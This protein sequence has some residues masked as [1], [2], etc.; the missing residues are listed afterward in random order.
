MGLGLRGHE[1]TATGHSEGHGI[2]PSPSSGGSRCGCRCGLMSP[3]R[4]IQPGEHRY[5]VTTALRQ[6][7]PCFSC[8]V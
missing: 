5:W 7:D 2:L 4:A 8:A 3:L 1:R 6:V